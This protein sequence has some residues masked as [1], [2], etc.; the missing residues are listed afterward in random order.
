MTK[1]LSFFSLFQPLNRWGR[2]WLPAGFVI[3]ILLF[4]L[5]SHAQSHPIHGV[6]TDSTGAP[7][8]GASIRVISTKIAGGVTLTQPDGSF[9]IN[10][11]E[12]AEA[13]IRL[14]GY[15]TQKVLLTGT[16]LNVKLQVQTSAL[17]EVV[18][19]GY[20][21]KK[22]ID[23]TGSIVTVGAKNI[24]N[25]PVTNLSSALAGQV[26]GAY[27]Y[28]TSGQPGSDGASIQIRGASTLSSTSPLV[29]IDG[30]IGGLNSVNPNDVESVTV[31]KD[32]ASIAIYGAQGANGVIL[33]TT[34]KG[35]NGAP[36]V[37]YTGIFSQT[38]PTGVPQ[39]VT[40]S[41]RYMQLMNEGFT[42]S[43][44][45]LQFQPDSI[46]L[47]IDAS[48]NPNGVTAFG[49]PNYVAY[50]NTDWSKVIFQHHLL[51]NHN[52]SV[53]G[54]NE[55]T[56]YLL[57]LG[58]LNDP[59]LVASS[60]YQKYQFRF[61]LESKI[62]K[63][64][65]VGTATYG[66]QGYYGMFDG[67]NLFNYLVQASPTTYPYWNGKY[68]S[69][70]A[71]GDKI[72]Q[73]QNLLYYT[74]NYT[75]SQPETYINTT[76]YGKV[77][78]IKGLTFEPRFNYTYDMSTAVYNDNPVATERWNFATMQQVTAPTTNANLSTYS[79]YSKTW[80]YTL[81]SLL[82]YNKT[83]ARDHHINAMLGFNQY[84]TQTYGLSVSGKGL[85]DPSAPSLTT[86]SSFPSTPSDSYSDWSMRSFFGRVTYD[87]QEK[88]LLEG[89]WRND[90]SSRF[91]PNFRHGNFPS[92]SGG[93]VLS[94]EPF[95]ASLR[96]HNIQSLKLRGSWGKSGNAAV[97]NYA[98]QATY[99]VVN[100]VFA[101][102]IS[103]GL[104]ITAMA[105]PNL[106]WETT[107]QT[108]IGLDVLALQHLEVNFDWFRKFTYGILFTAPL[109]P[110]AGT[111]SAPVGNFA[112]V[113]QNGMELNLSWHQAIHDFSYSVGA[114]VTYNYNNK[115]VQ[116]KGPLVAG[117]S[118]DATGNP[119]YN[120]NIGAVSS[121]SNNRVL[122]GHMINEFYLQSVYHGDGTYKAG[123]TATVANGPKSG[124]I[125]TPD[126]YQWVL[127]MYAAGYQFA[128]G[129][130][131]PTLAKDG[132]AKTAKLYYGDLIYAD[133]NGDKIFGNANDAKFMNINT[134]PKFMFGFTFNA[135][136]KG[137][138][139][140]MLWAAATG[141]KYFWNQTYFNS[142]KVAIGG[143]IPVR[144]AD[145]H[146]YYDPNN[147]TAS[148]IN[149][150]YPRLKQSDAID[151][152]ASDFWFYNASYAKLKNLS[153][154]Y[155]IPMEKLGVAK[156]YIK[157]LRIYF[158]GENLLTITNY[159][160]PDPEAGTSVGYPL[161]RQYAAGI[162]VRF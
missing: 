108:D 29:L 114:N 72:G 153:V 61:N 75:G 74:K 33:V 117:W 102:A 151:N 152:I 107:N 87:Y 15:V 115:V 140:S 54:G 5:Q 111:A 116:Y 65:T 57:S 73:A 98:W 69:T 45:G 16:T 127:D 123:G 113:G 149:G 90:A 26:P 154:G 51:Q 155:T 31:L 78:L 63:Y 88:Y 105:N 99:G 109:D 132:S 80:S 142:T 46:Q 2:L 156:S 147:A 7:V 27:I 22:K 12:G 101:G 3:T 135:S 112:Q 9:T 52:I 120:S 6:V 82:K 20:G 55:N 11:N 150:Y 77:Q 94:K 92:I 67:S 18:V 89:N 4:S 97:G 59:G 148:N 103:P 125:R 141:K 83:V 93:W 104:A 30:I 24:E 91:G 39:F 58:Y 32:A 81:E 34:K 50:P 25:R 131:D 47:F 41:A 146:Y 129:N 161:L 119:V 23:L 160:G 126:D 19:I 13:E 158:S 85:I 66:S 40:N 49:V 128:Q 8:A 79:S 118:T 64:I 60:G 145:N 106:H 157:S 136:W 95:L 21:V 96:D 44:G 84:Y 159:P 56:T 138:D 14:V 36:S 38:N 122:E 134:S 35:R 124:M 139:F 53:S 86:V 76:W 48:K 143:Q 28:Q 68:G 70:S 133:N 17:D 100:N 43:G 37:S 10:A 110:T 137:F 162:N 144:I 62:G 42:N 130:P 121:G 1:G 71:F